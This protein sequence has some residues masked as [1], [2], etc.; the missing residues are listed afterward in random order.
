MT[1]EPEKTETAP[2]SR[3]LLLMACGLLT[4]GLGAGL[5]VWMQT[6]NPSSDAQNPSSQSAITQNQTDLTDYSQTADGVFSDDPG[7]QNAADSELL[8]QTGPA[9]TDLSQSNTD[10]PGPSQDSLTTADLQWDSAEST[11]WQTTSADAVPSETVNL[12]NHIAIAD[13]ELR[14]GNYAK[15]LD[16]FRYTLGL[17]SGTAEAPIRFRMALCAEAAGQFEEARVRYR[18]VSQKFSQ[19]PW[20]GVAQLG[21]ARCLSALGRIDLLESGPLRNLLLDETFFPETVRG[22][23]FHT[24]GLAFSREILANAEHD[25]LDDRGLVIADW[26]PDPILI[27]DSLPQM[28][29][30]HSGKKFAATFQLL[31]RTDESPDSIYVRVHSTNAP[32]DVLLKAASQKSGFQCVLSPLAQTSLKGRRQILHAEDIS[33]SVLL[34]GLTVPFS[35]T[36]Q[37]QGQTIHISHHTETEPAQLSAFRLAAAERLLRNALFQAP[38]SRQA[39]HTRVALGTLLFNTRREADAAHVFRSQIEQYPRSPVDAETKFNLAKCLISLGQNPEASEHF[40]HSVDASGGQPLARAAAYIY[41]GRLQIEDEQYQAAVSSLVRAVALSEMGRLEKDAA[42]MLSSAYLL[43]GNPQG[44]NS[45]LMKRRTVLNAPETQ[46]AAA[47]LSAFSRFRAAVLE[48]RREREGRTLVSALTNF[49]PESQF[50]FHW[51]ILTAEAYEELGLQEQAIQKYLE[52]LQAVSA[53]RLKDRAL[54]QLA[55]RYRADNRLQDAASVLDSISQEQADAFSQQVALQTA[56]V[57]VDRGDSDSALKLCHFI[58]TKSDNPEIQRLALKTM[59][60]AF[61]QKQDHQAAI[62]CFSGRLPAMTFADSNP[63]TLLQDTTPQSTIPQNAVPQPENTISPFAQQE[64][65]LP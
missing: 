34:D 42:L 17:V 16:I 25:L 43:A 2:K 46:D 8:S 4:A 23:L 27:L 32:V 14:I 12:A 47:F 7:I 22:E 38:D 53:A 31:Q 45:V 59:G 19:S 20:A 18:A 54:L 9:G 57:A 65:E 10:N 24:C 41:V 63:P 11:E 56:L 33:L 60:R 50:G 35:L 64:D 40:L 51:I 52:S 37:Q 13:E 44:A 39:G 58:V 36:W 62:Y 29:T 3:K 26:T 61:E 48:D 1:S 28:L 55:S 6:E 21:E 15:A 49:K 30:E 5:G